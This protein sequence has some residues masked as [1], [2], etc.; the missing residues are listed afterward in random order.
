MITELVRE[1]RVGTNR[2]RQ[3]KAYE[4][5]SNPAF[6]GVL[7]EMEKGARRGALHSANVE[8]REK[9]RIEYLAIRAVQR[10]FCTV[11]EQKDLLAAEE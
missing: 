10:A 6:F 5:I 9:A 1:W 3:Q 8:D 7:T 2:Y 4:L 11:A